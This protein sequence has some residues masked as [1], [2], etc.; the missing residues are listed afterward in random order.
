MPNENLTEIAVVLDRSGSMF[1]IRSDMVGAFAHFIDEQRKEPGAC[2]VSLYQFD[3][4]FETVYQ[5]RAIAEVGA[6]NLDPRGNTALLDAMGKSISL[7]GERLAAKPEAERPGKV[8]I[9]VITDGLEN[10]SREWTRAQVRSRVEHQREQY[11]WQFAFLGANVDAF[12]EARSVGIPQG[13]ALDYVASASGVQTMGTILS[14]AVRSYRGSA[15]GSDA[16]LN[17]HP[18]P[19]SAAPKSEDQDG[20]P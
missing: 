11:A 15:V 5:E 1:Q 8:V 14:N 9:V 17:F 18:A 6:L 13:A 19:T 10:A 4:R 12:N 16:S 2:V 20:K 3:D 7:I